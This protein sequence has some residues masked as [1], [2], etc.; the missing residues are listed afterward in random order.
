MKTDDTNTQSKSPR[1]LIADDYPHA[2]ESLA[3][4]LR[5]QSFEVEVALDGRQAIEAADKFHPNIALLDLGM[6]KLNGYQ[7]AQWLREQP[8]AKKILVVALT[9]Y[10]Q[11]E[12]LQRSREAGF[13]AHLVKPVDDSRLAEV[14]A[15]LR[16][17]AF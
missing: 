11:Q 12:D 5:R 4:R 17:Q 6:P 9:G 1:I 2:A 3:R 10:G 7:V 13:D 14:L 8:W 15:Q 16:A